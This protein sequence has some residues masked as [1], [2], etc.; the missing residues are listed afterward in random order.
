M[1]SAIPAGQQILLVAM[2]YLL[3]KHYVADFVVQTPFQFKNKGRYGHPGGLLH[4]AIHAV[5]TIP[6]VLIVQPTM[7]Q[8]AALLVA[9]EFLVHYHIDWGKE[10]V[11]RLAALSPASAR[12]WQLFGFDQ[13]LHGMT[14]VVLLACLLGSAAGR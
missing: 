8:V 12:Y 7:P 1:F 10:Q 14:Y 9:L 4:A 5:L 3:L 13:L 2:S 6:L 11:N